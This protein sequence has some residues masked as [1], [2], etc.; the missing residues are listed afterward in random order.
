MTTKKLRLWAFGLVPVLAAGLVGGSAETVRADVAGWWT[1]A[2]VRENSI[3]LVQLQLSDSAGQVVGTYA[4][5]EMGLYEEPLRELAVSDSTVRMR[6]LYGPFELHRSDDIEQL[7]GSNEGWN[8]PLR[9]H[10]KR[11]VQPPQPF[12]TTR[13][14]TFRNSDVQLAGT[15]YLP[16]GRGP[17]PGVV[18]VHGGGDQPRSM[19]EYRSHLYGLVRRGIAVLIYDK[20]GSGDSEGN[21]HT[22]T[23]DDLAGDATAALQSLKAQVEVD[24]AQCGLYGISQGGW[25]AAKIG[26]KTGNEDLAFMVLNQGPAVSLWQQDIDRVRYSLRNDG[27]SAAVVDS[28]VALT[29]LYF[30]AIADRD[31]WP[32]Y[33]SVLD[34]AEADSAAW[35]EYAQAERMYDDEDMVWWRKNQYD[36][37]ADLAR[38][39]CPVLVIYGEA[40]GAVP[41]E[42]NLALMERYLVKAGVPH[43]IMLVPN[44]AHAVTLYPTLRGGS[45]AWPENFWQW[46]YRPKIDASVARWIHRHSDR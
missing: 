44:L 38:L 23:F 28:A 14:V 10:L 9:L 1:G 39:D 41:P 27:F 7:T 30:E 25:V 2:F 37:A 5:P 3:Q 24:A 8:P 18:L 21:Y 46:G 36:P 42:A 26:A 34:R 19:W 31:R 22:S 20:R 29:R 43:E 17:F 11:P 35:L 4:I 33:L 6:F 13:E 12:F 16:L 32:E 15:I 45:W 40:D